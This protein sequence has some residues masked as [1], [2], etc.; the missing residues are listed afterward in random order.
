M[1]RLWSCAL[2]PGSCL[3]FFSS[4]IAQAQI[5]PDNTL[6][7]N[8]VVTPSGNTHEITGGTR[9][10]NNLYH[11]FEQFSVT[12]GGEAFFNNPQA[13]ENIFTRVTG[14]S[15]SNIDGS[16]R[17]NSVANLFLLNPNGIIF[18]PNA[19][20]NIGGSFVATTA[21]SYRWAN[22]SQFSSINPQAPPLLTINVPVGLQT[23]SNPGKIVVQGTGNNLGLN[24]NNFEIIRDFRPV[25]LQVKPGKT[26]ALVGGDILLEGGNLTA[27]GGR[28][29][30][31]SVKNGR[32]L[33]GNVD[34]DLFLNKTQKTL[35]YGNIQ[36]SQA[37]SVDTSGAVGGDIHVQGRNLT[38]SDGSVIFSNILS[39]GTGGNLTV[40]ISESV[41]VQ[42][43]SPFSPIPSGLFVD[44]AS[45]SNSTGGNLNVNTESLRV[46]DGGQIGAN[47]FGAG[48]AGNLSVQ[49]QN[50]ELSGGANLGPSGLF[51]V[52][53][54]GAAGKGGNLTIATDRL[55]I[56]GGAQVSVSTFGSGD[57]GNLSLRATEV[58]IFGTSLGN[59]SSR[60]SANVEQGASGTGGNLFVETD[61]LRL[62]EGGQIVT[63]TFGSGD[64]GTLTV[65]SQ[66]VE[67]IGTS[68]ASVPSGLLADVASPDTT[69][70]SGNI[71]VET[72]RLRIA[73]GAIVG[74]STFGIGDAGSLTVKAQEI[75]V[76]G[77][78]EPGPS[79]LA[80]TVV[81]GATG[82]GGDL[83]IQTERLRVSDG[84][85]I[86]VSTGG[87]GNAGELS[88]NADLV[89]LIGTSERQRSAS[90]LFANAVIG[91]GDGGN[92]KLNSDRLII[93]DGAT[94]S[95]S[96]FSSNPNIPPGQGRAG[97]IDIKAN[98]LLLD[99]QS[100][101][102]A[103]TV[104]G[105][106]GNIN[107]HVEESLIARNN[108]QITAETFGIGKGGTIKLDAESLEIAS[109]S[110]IVT[111]SEGL[112]QAGN[113]TIT[114]DRINLNRGNI[115]AIS[116]QSGGGDISLTSEFILLENGS[117]ISTSVL[118]STGGG[119]NINIDT[120]IFIAI[121]NS[122]IRADAV[123]G[124]GGNIQINA[125]GLFLSPDSNITAS[126]QYGVDGTI[127]IIDPNVNR[128]VG[129]VQ[130]PEIMTD[131]TSLVASA[132]VANRENVF[133]VTGK[134]GLPEDPSQTLRGETYWVDRR[135]VDRTGVENV[136]D[137]P[138][139]S[140]P[141]SR[142][143]DSI[144]EAKGWVINED[145]TLLLVAEPV[146][147]IIN[148]SGQQKPQ[149]GGKASL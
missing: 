21:D 2:I 7:N 135:S 109:G 140:K 66:D 147:P 47:I 107:I 108:S 106:G 6:P 10:N 145:G 46:A 60:L 19:S 97:D 85:Q 77:V 26:L 133:A 68:S 29:E 119:G 129:I 30:L 56:I 17:A 136:Q 83:T 124:P 49:A 98:S 64:A 80:T 115:A 18:G 121:E 42:G 33:V 23:G 35:D 12:T 4:G 146:D 31:W 70:N 58:G 122:D 62:T 131:L 61:R 73:D 22:G 57:A 134:G 9:V 91:T 100:N 88:I 126:S 120:D 11:S 104:S 43:I 75:E 51:A 78:G 110:E 69:G 40:K 32:I 138:V 79:L 14:R 67:I 54:P 24:P 148:P 141:S 8:S 16:L 103:A 94:I 139:E 96:N 92:I 111:D 89:E 137:S 1:Y 55:Q 143:Q 74:A 102:T 76:I 90:G 116:K 41:N 125:Q 5:V 52:V 50:I 142:S 114:S 25:G 149:C 37:S 128:T 53:T 15:I 130:L 144:V 20:L 123:R 39:S 63:N 38:L 65:K 44:V 71:N 84:G 28:V 99:R 3:G 27:E 105:G 13:I 72:D 59:S 113:I 101:I 36:L 34:G 87:A 45:S 127:E 95:T 86:A 117:T 93:L 118:D 132:C 112:G 81:P 48:K 82:K